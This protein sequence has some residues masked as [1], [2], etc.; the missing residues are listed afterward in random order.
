MRRAEARALRALGTAGA[1]PRFSL[2][3]GLRPRAQSI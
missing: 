2:Q 1:M 3:A